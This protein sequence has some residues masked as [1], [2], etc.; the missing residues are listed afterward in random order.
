MNWDYVAGLFDGEGSAGIYQGTRGKYT[1][2]MANLSISNNHLKTLKIVQEFIGCG[3]I[4]G[5][6]KHYSL[7]IRNHHDVARVAGQLIPRCIIKQEKLKRVFAFVES[8]KW[9]NDGPLSFVSNDQLY[10][11][12]VNQ[13]MTG[14]SI[15][16]KF[17][18]SKSAVYKRLKRSIV[19]MSE[20]ER[21]KSN[22]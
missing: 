10:E 7:V 4:H 14:V 19:T 18:C 15:A 20:R 13:G 17:G 12:Y 9:L 16:R 11:L 3:R 22:R 5:H 2:S 1:Y 6:K 8:K 21:K